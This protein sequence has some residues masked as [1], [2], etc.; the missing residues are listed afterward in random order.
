[1]LTFER[2]IAKEQPQSW[3]LQVMLDTLAIGESLPLRLVNLDVIHN[4]YEN[5]IEITKT[6][7]AQER[8]LQK[9]RAFQTNVKSETIY[10]HFITQFP[11]KENWDSFVAENVNTSSCNRE[12]GLF[13]PDIELLLSSIYPL[14]E[15]AIFPVSTSNP[16][17]LNYLAGIL[18][19][20]WRYFLIIW[21]YFYIRE[22]SI[23][24]GSKEL[25]C[26]KAFGINNWTMV[27][28]A[29]RMINNKIHCLI[30]GPVF[31]SHLPLFSDEEYDQTIITQV[32]ECLKPLAK[33]QQEF[34]YYK[35]RLHRAAHAVPFFP[36]IRLNQRVKR[37]HS[38]LSFVFNTEIKQEYISTHQQISNL[39]LWSL[40]GARYKNT[41][42]NQSITKP[43][44]LH[45]QSDTA[46]NQCSYW[47]SMDILP[48]LKIQVVENAAFS[49][50]DIA[51]NKRK[52]YEYGFLIQAYGLKEE[53]YDDLCISYVEL[54]SAYTNKNKQI[55]QKH[56]LLFSEWLQSKAGALLTPNQ[57]E[58]VKP[59][60]FLESSKEISRWIANLLRADFCILYQF[61]SRKSS[62]GVLKAYNCYFTDP[63]KKSFE[64]ALKNDLNDIALEI[65]KRKQSISYRAIDSSEQKICYSYNAHKKDQTLPPGETLYH[66]PQA[67]DKAGNKSPF[68]SALSTPIRFSG[69]RLGVIELSGKHAWQFRY[70]HKIQLQQ[71]A[72]QLA[73]FLYQH[74]FMESMHAIQQS[75]LEF[76]AEKIKEGELYNTICESITHLFLCDGCS[77][78]VRNEVETQMMN[79]MGLH[80][81]QLP[82]DKLYL[83]TENSFIA[84]SV[85]EIEKDGEIK[86][87]SSLISNHKGEQIN[88]D[89]MQKQGIHLITILPILESPE[90]PEFGAKVTAT[91]NLYNRN[92]IGFDDSWQ[93]TIEFMSRYIS[94]VIGAV[95]AFINERGFLANVYTHEI[96]HDA[97]YIADKAKK[98]YAERLYL[99]QDL[100][101]LRQYIATPWFQQ[102]LP[103][104]SISGTLVNKDFIIKLQ[105]NLNSSW[106]LPSEDIS[107]FAG[108]LHTRVAH[109]FGRSSEL[110]K[111][112]QN[113]A[114]E[115][116]D[117]PDDIRELDID[118]EQEKL[119]SIRALYNSLITGEQNI[120][121]KGLYTSTDFPPFG[122]I[123][124]PLVMTIV[125]RNL[126]NNAFKYSL[127]H[128]N[129]DIKLDYKHF[130]GSLVFTIK[131][132]AVSLKGKDEI[133]RVLQKNVRG[134]NALET[135]GENKTLGKGI[136]LY[137]VDKVCKHLLK[138]DFTFKEIPQE[139]GISL[140]IA[141]IF[142]PPSK[143]ERI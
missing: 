96:W 4:L 77:L 81:F 10:Q 34:E 44:F 19:P 61:D 118:S 136:G 62:L 119:V 58:K 107:F 123:T 139:Q 83:N 143:V 85:R 17:P 74:R 12:D 51:E 54:L 32:I 26:R 28:C 8:Y 21:L 135:E 64:N 59:S 65:D 47:L 116:G 140:F 98:L 92:T 75:M 86:P 5:I 87:C 141:E 134:S 67:I 127:P 78:W 22:N 35:N 53:L 18:F 79:R 132:Y 105:Q 117:I 3:A 23:E 68:A 113:L 100:E 99:K 121:S 126:L 129:V 13:S 111:E 7:I 42:L 104:A 71:I 72:A 31:Q 15:T 39:G 90:D 43:I 11:S 133:R 38:A 101:K 50:E 131:N 16:L 94:F 66:S 60:L 73:P 109:L 2:H 36:E 89:A 106:F 20:E 91:I 55:M 84:K 37:V 125:L 137:T 120:K 40:L 80:H 102:R 93:G 97:S 49:L 29:P 122:L 52:Y 9:K 41:L 82:A 142:I 114:I 130:N 88:W 108:M 76:H 30:A 95:N 48:Q 124:R 27:F 70:A 115:M 112:S 138:L 25:K 24:S 103:A 46:H 63:N 14:I 56:F 1:M 6:D 128:K 57:D 33:R 45:T 110:S 69:R